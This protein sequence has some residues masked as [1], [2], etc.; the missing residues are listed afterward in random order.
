M[1]RLL[2]ILVSIG[3][4]IYLFTGCSIPTVP[5]DEEEGTDEDGV[6]RVVMV[7]L[8]VGPACPLCP[9]AKKAIAT[10]L[11]EYKFDKLV[12][13][14]EY[15]W[16]NDGDGYTGWVTEETRNRFI[17]YSGYSRHTPDAYFNGLNQAVHNNQKPYYDKYK[18]AIKAELDK[19]ALVSIVASYEVVSNKVSISGEI[20]NVSSETLSDIVIGAM[21]YEDSVPLGSSI[22]NHVVRDIITYQEIGGEELITSFGPEGSHEFS[23]T[24]SS[25]SN[26]HDMS[27]IH[28]VVYVQAPYSSTKE[29]LQAYYVE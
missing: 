27:N 18:E 20:N 21:V 29:I 1:R 22:V 13:L 8:F 11:Q 12:V 16:D 14:E 26:V 5:S 23:L 17:W 28:V 7:E 6:D 3:L 15:G 19:P 9:G 10:L 25:L 24:S 2:L 4:I